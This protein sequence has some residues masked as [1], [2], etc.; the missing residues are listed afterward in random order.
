VAKI[1][2]VGELSAESVELVPDRGGVRV[3]TGA[4]HLHGGAATM[5]GE[6]DL[7]RS[8]AEVSLPH[9]RFG[10]VLAVAGTGRLHLGDH[11]I[12]MRDVAIGRLSPAASLEARGALDE[13]GVLRPIS[14]ELAHHDGFTIVLRGEKVPLAPLSSLVPASI[15]LGDARASGQLTLRKVRDTTQLVVDGSVTGLRLDHKTVA[16][17]PVPVDAGVSATL[18]ISPQAIAVEHAMLSLGAAHW[19]GSGWLRRGAPLSGQLDVRLA[20]AQCM[21]LVRSLPVQVRGPLDG[22]AMTGTFGGHARLSIDL[23]AP[24]GQGVDLETSIS[25][26]CTVTA[27]PPAAD[28]TSLKIRAEMPVD[29]V[30]LHRL[31]KYVPGAFISAEDGRFWDHAGFDL[32]QI[33]RSFEIDLRDGKIS[34]GGS[35]ISQ[36]LVKNTFLTMRRSLDRKIQEAVLTWRLESRLDKKTIL[37]R[38]LNIIELGPHTFGT[39]PA[40]VYWFGKSPRELEIKEAAFLAALTCE[41]TTMGK[42]IRKAGGLDPQSAERVDIILRAMRRDGVIDKD[43]FDEAR[44]Q[45]LHFSARALRQET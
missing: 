8:A 22:I 45:P 24:P 9:V 30:L 23:A 37:E 32:Q 19:T 41:P 16:P 5:F 40:A 6:L 21:D 43:E 25:N 29:W 36:Q 26:A 17:E 33:A 15:R 7:R 13:H 2:G 20:P 18:T 38:Y 39:R 10:R 12:A 3:I 27:E 35:T 11:I 42:R 1:A 34:R 28:V 4:V 14:L 31:P 44:E